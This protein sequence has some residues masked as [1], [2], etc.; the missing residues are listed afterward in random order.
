MPR[1]IRLPSADE[2]TRRR[3]AQL[4][5]D[6]AILLQDLDIEIRIAFENAARVVVGRIAGNEHGQR[7]AA[8]Q[9]VQTALRRIAQA[10]DFVAREHV[11]AG[12][13]GNARAYRGM[14]H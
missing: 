7:T 12:R 11:H 9:G 10:G 13:R 3:I 1:M 2:R 5:L 14:L 8:Q 6:A 4:E